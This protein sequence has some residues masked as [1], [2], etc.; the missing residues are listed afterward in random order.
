MRHL[1]G[2]GDCDGQLTQNE[3]DAVVYS[4]IT[5]SVL[6]VL[7]ESFI[8]GMIILFKTYHN[9]GQRLILNL[10]IAALL[11][12]IPYF[13]GHQAEGTGCN[14]QAFTVT[15]F[16]WNVLMWVLCITH[17]LALNILYERAGEGLEH[18]YHALGWGVGLVMAIIPAAMN[19]YGPSG[20]W[21]WI[22]EDH[23]DTTALRF[24]IWY[25]PLW[26]GILI[27]FTAN[28]HI[29][30]N[31]RE[32]ERRWEGTYN[33]DTAAEKEFLRAQ[34]TPIKWYPLVYTLCMLFPTMNRIQNAANPDD[35]IF[36]LL[37]LHSISSPL[38]GLINSFI[39]AYNTDASIWRQCTVA[40]IQRALQLRQGGTVSEFN[41]LR[42]GIANDDDDANSEVH[43]DI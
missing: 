17:K 40:G 38:Q 5:A 4:R 18:T 37:L 24:G 16:N 34:V 42:A 8:I 19:M 3:C 31:V 14:I 13:M 9:Y 20:V 22:K 1:L 30:R 33:P 12:T 2:A 21:C 25:V 6:A 41:T 27:L 10:T 7:G 15:W 36:A 23:N 32:R 43:T 11:N 29:I 35:P 28:F 39:Y 26:I